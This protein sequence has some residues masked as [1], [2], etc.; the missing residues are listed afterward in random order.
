MHLLL[1]G[2]TIAAVSGWAVMPAADVFDT[3][4]AG[5]FASAMQH[6]NN[7]CL[8]SSVLVDGGSMLVVLDERG[9]ITE[10]EL[11]AMPAVA[12]QELRM[13]I[14]PVFAAATTPISPDA[15]MCAAVG[16][17]Q[18]V[19]VQVEV[20]NG[21]GT[22]VIE[23]NGDR[24]E[25]EIDLGDIDFEQISEEMGEAGID[26]HAVMGRLL[27]GGLSPEVQA[28]V[29]VEMVDDEGDRHR[30]R[31]HLGGND[32]GLHER[33]MMMM[34]GGGKSGHRMPGHGQTGQGM[35]RP[36]MGSGHACPM[37]GG[38]GPRSMAGR[39]GHGGQG[40]MP[41]QGPMGHGGWGEG[42]GDMGEGHGDMAA[43]MLREHMHFL[44]E[45]HEDPERAWEIIESLP[46]EV[47]RAHEELLE[48][49]MG[50]DDD[51][52]GEHEFF[53]RAG[54]FDEKITVA[55]RVAQRL[56]D[57][58]AMAVFGVWQAREHLDPE[59]RIAMLAPMVGN[60]RLRTS[61]RNAAAFVVMEAHGELDDGASAADA[62]RDMILRNGVME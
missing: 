7:D 53:E 13:A 4:L 51:D 44:A 12:E 60:E 16:D 8:A 56:N 39:G 11:G 24:R 35:G 9:G 40:M 20:A 14:P 37:C 10:V 2:S 61:V 52:H 3:G 27:S 59:E 55:R 18:E 50:G 48:Q 42:H 43:G 49:L 1:A 45:M 21:G 38:G 30:K 31:I 29:V 33:H 36:G 23:H 32:D 41:P 34:F 28:E 6:S 5:H 58:E 57:A 54:E 17:D 26:M 46:P 25:I 47:R 62:L 15:L 19:D 22:I